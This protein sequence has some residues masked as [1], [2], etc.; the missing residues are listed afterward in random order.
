MKKRLKSASA[1]LIMVILLCTVCVL[2][3]NEPRSINVSRT[4]DTI[5][6]ALAYRDIELL[7]EDIG[8]FRKQQFNIILP[9]RINEAAG[10]RNL[11]LVLEF[12]K[13]DE[14]LRAV[15]IMNRAQIPSVI[16][17]NGD[18][19][20][21]AI[22]S[23]YCDV[24]FEFAVNLETGYVSEVDM[25][26]AITE[27]Q[28]KF[29]LDYGES[30]GIFVHSCGKLFCEDMEELTEC[31]S[32]VNLTVFTCGNGANKLGYSE[33]LRVINRIVRL[34]DWNIADYFSSI[35]IL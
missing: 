29:Y 3:R 20:I 12:G 18:C 7:E 34:P 31:K 22:K 6:Y 19:D 24:E 1:T 8:Y 10:S 9:K 16:L 15:E 30:T 33:G 26:R 17:V 32:F 14:M 13:P 5:V 4:N 11:I 21:G 27:S 35:A 2:L 28:M 25:V 23:A